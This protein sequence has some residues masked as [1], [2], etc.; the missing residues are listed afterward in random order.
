MQARQCWRWEL[1]NQKEEML[2][3]SPRTSDTKSQCLVA[4]SLVKDSAFTAP[5]YD[6]YGTVLPED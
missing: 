4:I 6:E 2:A 5:V 3:V 1:R